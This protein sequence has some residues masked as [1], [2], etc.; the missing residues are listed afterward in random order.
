MWLY[1][2]NKSKKEIDSIRHQHLRNIMVIVLVVGRQT[3]I[4]TS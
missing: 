2:G 4:I 3:S 1:V